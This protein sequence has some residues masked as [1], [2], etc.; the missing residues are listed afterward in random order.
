MSMEHIKCPH[1]G[2]DAGVRAI[3]HNVKTGMTHSTCPKYHK[4]FTW[5]SDHGE[6]TTYK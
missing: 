2:G 5:Q 1:C 3:N 4:S 6:I